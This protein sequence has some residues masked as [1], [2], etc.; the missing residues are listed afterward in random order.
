MNDA[1]VFELN[2]YII[3]V[4][5]TWNETWEFTC[6]WISLSNVSGMRDEKRT[7]GEVSLDGWF[8]EFALENLLEHENCWRVG[9]SLKLNTQMI[10]DKSIKIYKCINLLKVFP[11]GKLKI[12]SENKNIVMNRASKC[13]RKL[14][15][16]K[17]M[18]ETFI[19]SK[20]NL[21]FDP[22]PHEIQPWRENFC[23]GET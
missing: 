19:S 6:N 21:N 22:F 2:G 15:P 12:S 5:Q 13:R 10:S 9:A 1:D 16:F 3:L 23:L 18:F 20:E 4:L 17:I 14:K 11:S 7:K 8:Y